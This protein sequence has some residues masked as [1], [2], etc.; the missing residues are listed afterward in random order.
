MLG[1]LSSPTPGASIIFRGASPVGL[2]YTRFRSRWGAR[3]DRVAR[4]RRSLAS[5]DAA[6][7][8]TP[9]TALARAGDSRLVSRT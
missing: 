3:S 2:P 7:P 5:S 4:S 9:D 8:L 1:T 6:G